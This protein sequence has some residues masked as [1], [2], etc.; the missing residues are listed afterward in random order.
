MI[1]C[2]ADLKFVASNRQGIIINPFIAHT[3]SPLATFAHAQ[4][5]CEHYECLN[6]LPI[7]VGILRK[8]L[9]IYA[10]FLQIFGFKENHTSIYFLPPLELLFALQKQLQH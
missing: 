7:I 5:T 10:Y 1:W 3:Y 9:S 6:I 2:F 8:I 4:S